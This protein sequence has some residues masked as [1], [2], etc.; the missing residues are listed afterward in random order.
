M[1]GVSR[2][3]PVPPDAVFGVLADGWSYAGWVVGNAHIRK[4][5]RDWPAEGS[6][7]HHSAGM[8]PV[9]V[10]DTS[11]VVAVRQDEL[12]EL[13]ARLWV[14]GRA[15]VRFTLRP[16]EDGATRVIMEEQ[17]VSGPAG[18]V[19]AAA[20]ALLLKPRNAEALARLSDIVVARASGDS[21]PQA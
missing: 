11:T 21:K 14:L 9:Q 1:I 3:M 2:V 17:A 7:I 13:D 5:D 8:W 15:R 20:Q 18:L 6:R 19:P 10:P 4:V 16:E 12:L